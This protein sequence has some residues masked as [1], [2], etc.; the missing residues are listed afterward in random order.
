M[1]KMVRRSLG[2]I[3]TLVMFLSLVLNCFLQM[4]TARRDMTASSQNLFWQIDQI[5][6][7]NQVE[8]RRV[9]EEF[10]ARCLI[11]AKAAAYIVQ[12]RPS[13]LEDQEEMEKV[14]ELLQVDEFHVFDEE[15]TLYA[16]SEPKYFGYTFYSGSQM[17]FF[18]PMLKDRTLE[19]CQSVTP[20]TAEGKMMQYAAVWREDKRGIVQIGMEPERV[21]E[22]TKKNEL[23]YIFSLLTADKG[24]ALYAVDPE[25]FEIL[26]STDAQMVG[27]NLTQLGLDPGQATGEREGFH[28]KVSGRWSYCVFTPA[29]SVILGRICTLDT[30]Y[31]NAFTNSLLLALYLLAIAVI[32]IWSI[33][34]YLDQVILSGIWAVNR[35]LESITNGNLD[36]R[37]DVRTTPEFSQLSDQINLM[38]ASLLDTTDKLSRVLD[39]AHIPIGA[40]EYSQGMARVRATS[41]VPEILALTPQERA[42]LLSDHTLFEQRLSQLRGR[43][44]DGGQSIFQLS[45]APE[46]YIKMESFRRGNNTF[47]ILMDVTWDVTERRRIEQERDED[48]LTGTHSR[49]AFYAQLETLFSQPQRMGCGV[50][51]IADADN[52]KRVNDCWGHD[53]G[54]R[55]LRGVADILRCV[56]APQH[57]LARLSGD[58]FALLI[59]GCT[60]TQQ[61]QEYIE[62]LRRRR[63]GFAIRTTTQQPLQVTLS[64][65]CAFYPQDG[66][67]YHSLLRCADARMYQ[68]KQQKKRPPKRVSAW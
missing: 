34:K 63:E 59:Y 4:R 58:E 42:G 3:I 10:D 64:M 19:M 66:A 14:A 54:D 7:Q 25:S 31:H 11:Q 32:M 36:E 56:T 67:D 1:K 24:A 22:A 2:G 33:S 6:A 20:N 46:R 65:G 17:Q 52:L 35:K 57:I 62:Q 9:T 48:L 23:S 5:L 26:G 53:N 49:R 28:A 51:V 18:L 60:S 21:V 29:D 68:E 44:A 40:Y 8:A 39:M 37:V 45:E 12:Y 38:V 61:L 47:G 27:Q 15:G 16:G 41:R 50:L 55:Y 13:I 30:L 43:P